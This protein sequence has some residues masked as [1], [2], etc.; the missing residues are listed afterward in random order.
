MYCKR[1]QGVNYTHAK[2]KAPWGAGLRGL[3]SMK[4]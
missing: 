2:R 4:W 1:C 3:R